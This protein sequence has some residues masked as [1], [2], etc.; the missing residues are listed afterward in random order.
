MRKFMSQYVLQCVITGEPAGFY[1][2]F[3][4]RR[5]KLSVYFSMLERESCLVSSVCLM[6][7][8]RKEEIN[9]SSGV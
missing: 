6:E 4:L 5:E 9:S 2:F 3:F 7:N 8:S 1:V